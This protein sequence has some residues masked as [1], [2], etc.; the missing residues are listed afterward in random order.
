MSWWATLPV[1]LV[2]LLVFMVPGGL[3]G[4]A[5]GA[6]RFTLVALAPAF[7]ASIAGLMAFAAPFLGLRWNVWIVLVG[8]ILLSAVALVVRKLLRKS[9]PEPK[10]L[11]LRPRLELATAAAVIIA[12]V[13]IG[14]RLMYA[15][16]GPENISQTY[17][18]V[19]HL[20]AIRWALDSGNASPLNLGLFTGISAYPSGWHAMVSLVVEVSGATIPVTVNVVNIVVGALV[21][22]LGCVYFAQVVMGRRIVSTVIAAILSAGF[23]AFP[24]LMV[25]WGVLY[26]NLLSISLLPAALGAFVGALGLGR[27]KDFSTPIHWLVGLA[28]VPGMALAHPST[29]MALLAFLLPAVLL[30]YLRKMRTLRRTPDPAHRKL[31]WILSGLTAAGLLVFAAAWYIVRP[32]Q[33]AA[34]WLAVQSSAQAIGEIIMSAPMGRPAAGVMGILLITGLVVMISRREKPWLLLMF[35][36]GAFLYFYVSGM[37]GRPRG[38]ITGIWYYDP[39]RLAALMPMVTIGPA[40]LG[41]TWLFDKGRQRAL[42]WKTEVVSQG[43]FRFIQALDAKGALGPVMAVVLTLGFLW[44]TQFATVGFGAYQASMRYNLTNDSPLVSSDEMKLL[45]RL[46][47]EVPADAVIAGM[48]SNGSA[49]AY[50]LS[51]RPVL[52][53]HILTTHGA[54]TDTINRS[55][56]FAASLGSVCDA[57]RS[58]NVKY[59]LDFGPRS[60]TGYLTGYNGVYNVE[61]APEMTLVDSEGRFA[62]LYRVD[63]CW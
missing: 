30:L 51:G 6:R 38:L 40:V 50:A 43:R 4:W 29:A 53:P 13:V 37:A 22:P 31:A 27:F 47:D 41:G 28:V 2:T 15:F 60:V 39:N 26:P 16:G 8:A 56:K 17:D 20:N 14:Y 25:D 24:M 57:V 62:K 11:P 63:A 34:G 55:L 21:W 23:S 35:L 49:L 19:F 18:N 46:A 54:E 58:E 1:F 45:Q 7:S 32:P 12:V 61:N 42:A 10:R 3:F 36:V 44:G 9:W 33:S 59:I 5:A 48:P 52:Q